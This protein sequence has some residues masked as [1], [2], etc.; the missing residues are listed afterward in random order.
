MSSYNVSRSPVNTNNLGIPSTITAHPPWRSKT[1]RPGY[2]L[3]GITMLQTRLRT[4]S[5]SSWT[6]SIPIYNMLSQLL[7]PRHLQ[8]FRYP[9]HSSTSTQKSLNAFEPQPINQN[10]FHHQGHPDCQLLHGSQ[11][12]VLLRHHVNWSHPGAFLRCR[13]GVPTAA[14]SGGTT[15]FE[16]RPPDFENT[17]THTHLT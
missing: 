10:V 16:G 7:P 15:T 9:Q 17:H 2:S 4:T 6:I 12:L 14:A 13:R 1:L 5:N 8:S 11:G 3:P